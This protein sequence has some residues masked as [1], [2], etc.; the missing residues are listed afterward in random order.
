FRSSRKGAK[1]LQISAK[2]NKEI[3]SLFTKINEA[4]GLS[5]NS[6]LNLLINNYVR[7]K[8]YLLDEEY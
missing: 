3:Y 5:N 2:V 6:S 7:D 4:N 1:D 8:K